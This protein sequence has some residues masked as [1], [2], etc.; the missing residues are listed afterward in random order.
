MKSKNPKT[1]KRTTEILVRSV[2]DDEAK[3][4][5]ATSEHV[6]GLVVEAASLDELAKEVQ[7][8][9][10]RLLAL[11]NKALPG[12]VPEVV[13]IAMYQRLAPAG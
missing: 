9:V 7:V 2:W 3:V 1:G 12:R 11:Q 5:T 8:L 4:W 13:P 6:P 10:P